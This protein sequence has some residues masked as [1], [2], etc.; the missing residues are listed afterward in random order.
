MNKK[1]AAVGVIALVVVSL[2]NC[3]GDTGANAIQQNTNKVSFIKDSSIFSFTKQLQIIEERK[4]QVEKTQRNTIKMEKLLKYLKTRKNKTPYVFAG[5][6]P[7][8]GWD[9]SGLVLWTYEQFGITLKHSAT[10]QA[11]SGTR[12][13]YKNAKPGD[14]VTFS[15]GSDYWHYHAAI[16]L[17]NGM[18]VDA[19]NGYGT[20][21]VQPLT[22]FKGNKIRFS[23]I[24]QTN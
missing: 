24:V 23:R 20:T 7:K 6:S 1:F 18:I 13:S 5:S 11:H 22:N 4:K 12:V 17:G 8:W 16:Y 19:N 3:T 21:V 9:C 15:W 2:T 14:I 10:A